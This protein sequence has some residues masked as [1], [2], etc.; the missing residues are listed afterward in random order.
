MKRSARLKVVDH[1]TTEQLGGRTYAPQAVECQI[2][3]PPLEERIGTYDPVATIPRTRAD[4]P[5]TGHCP[6]VRCKHHNWNVAGIDRGGRRHG[7]KPPPPTLRA[8]WLV[9]APQPACSLAVAALGAHSGRRVARILGLTTRRVE[10]IM[11]RAIAKLRARGVDLP[12]PDEF[13]DPEA[14]WSK[15]R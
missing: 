9:G 4:C 10:I 1:A 13:P 6:H 11:A 2:S 5:P 3:G 8:E 15:R 12:D 14:R 7:G